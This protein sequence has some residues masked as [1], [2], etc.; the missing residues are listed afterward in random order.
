MSSFFKKWFQESVF[1]SSSDEELEEMLIFQAEQQRLERMRASASRT[2]RLYIDRGFIEGHNRLFNDYFAENP[3]Y[4]HDR[5]RRRFRM[6]RDLFLRIQSALEAHEPYFQ[7]KMDAAGKLGLSSLQKIIAVLGMLAYGVFADLLDEYVRI[8]E[9]T[10]VLSMKKFVKTVISVFGNE[11]LR[12][13]NSDDVARLL[14]IGESRGFPGMLG[15]IDCIHWKWK[16]CPSAWKGQFT[17]H[18]HEPTLILEAIAS[19]D[20]WIWHAFFGLSGSHNDINVLDRSF[21]FSDLT[22]GRFP[23]VHYYVNDHHYSIGYYLAYGIYPSWA[24]FVKTI[25]MPQT[26]KARHFKRMQES[27]RKDVERAFGVLQARFA[28]VRRPARYF[29]RSTLHNIML[30]CI[31]LHNMIVEDERHLHVQPD[32][33][34]MYDQAEDGPPTPVLEHLRTREFQDFVNQYIRIQDREIHTQLQA[35]LVEHLWN[36]HSNA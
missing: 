10:A 36:I 27:C 35:D 31:I 33:T 5:F 4:P 20:L 13:P 6:G 7:Q 3:V 21:V 24:T 19:Y 29:K 8:G 17:G 26:N 22:Q 2:P 1:D 12:S 32:I 30:V 23:P 9:S 14:A 28:I 25:P 34:Y 11:Y 18:I 16:N 15:S